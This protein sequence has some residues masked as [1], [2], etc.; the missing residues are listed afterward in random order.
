LGGRRIAQDAHVLA[1]QA[2]PSAGKVERDHRFLG[3]T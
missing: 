3:S 2:S 1:S